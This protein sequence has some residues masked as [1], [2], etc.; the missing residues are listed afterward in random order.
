MMSYQL[1]DL[2]PVTIAGITV[3]T[4]NSPAGLE[5]I[6]Q[7]WAT[8][9]RDGVMNALGALAEGPICEAYFDYESDAQGAYTVILGSRVPADAPVA[10]GLQRVTLPAARYAKFS[11]DDPKAIYAAW[12]HIWQRQDIE[13]SYSGDFEVIGENSADI[14]I[15]LRRQG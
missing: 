5:R 14:Y 2:G 1:T 15:A 6:G 8:F 12:Q 11:I 3:R 4:D 10:A 9:F 13:R 7:L